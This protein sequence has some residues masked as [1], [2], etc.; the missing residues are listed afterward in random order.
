[1][2]AD[3]RSSESTPRYS[4]GV[5]QSLQQTFPDAQ[6]Q[7]FKS[8]NFE[9]VRIYI[10]P[11]FMSGYVNE[12][13]LSEYIENNKFTKD[14]VMQANDTLK[15]FISAEVELTFSESDF[16]TLDLKQQNTLINE[17]FV[18]AYSMI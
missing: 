11:R 2:T 18:L 14:Q 12:S 13:R 6:I 8:E 16:S 7:F 17:I 9:S 5:W 4:E 3:T 10:L 15:D 1:M